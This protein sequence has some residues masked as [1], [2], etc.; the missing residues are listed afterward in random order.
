MK[1]KF[2]STLQT[3]T[4]FFKNL[5]QTPG[6]KLIIEGCAAAVILGIIVAIIFSNYN[7]PTEDL[8]EGV[9]YIK[10]LEK[11]DTAPIEKAMKEI[12]KQ[13]RKEAME[14]GEMDVWQQF[15]DAAILGDSRAVGFSFYNLVEDNRVF[16]EAGATIRKIPESIESLKVLNPSTVFLC[17]GLNDISIGFWNDVDSYIAELDEMLEQLHSALPDSVIYVNSIIPAT[18]PAFARSEKWRAIPDWNAKIKQH[19][20]DNNVPYIDVSATVEAHK[21]LYDVD[22]IHMQIAFY[23][24]WAIDMITEVNENE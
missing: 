22:G 16:A 10:T 15:N 2:N 1:E 3:V 11:T 13:E 14:S 17:F 18:D 12:K 5:F 20:Q 4:E 21:D 6:R 23:D 8:K 24:F 19:C 7:I 9:E